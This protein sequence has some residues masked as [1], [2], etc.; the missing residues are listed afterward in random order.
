MRFRWGLKRPLCLLVARDDD[1]D[2]DDDDDLKL[3]SGR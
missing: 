2:D 1:D 3:L